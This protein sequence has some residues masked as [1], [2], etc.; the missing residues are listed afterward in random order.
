MRRLNN[1]QMIDYDYGTT[2]KVSPSFQD[3][4]LRY[5]GCARIN[6]A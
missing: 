1:Y 4:S 6:S 5:S 3:G 2:L